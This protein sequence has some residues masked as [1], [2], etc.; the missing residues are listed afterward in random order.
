M[1][2]EILESLLDKM[3]PPL[4]ISQ[5]LTLQSI[6]CT[7]TDNN[8]EWAVK[9]CGRLLSQ[10]LMKPHGVQTLIEETFSN[11]RGMMKLKITENY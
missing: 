4:V 11:V 9:G 5:L 1:S 6:A 7:A 2:S 10:Q 3:Y 8:C